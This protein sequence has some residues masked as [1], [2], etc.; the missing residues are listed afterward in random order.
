MLNRRH[1]TTFRRKSLN[2]RGGNLS[3]ELTST[4]DIPDHS[5]NGINLQLASFIYHLV[6]GVVIHDEIR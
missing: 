2:H 6:K 5:T 4:G 1:Q 3:L